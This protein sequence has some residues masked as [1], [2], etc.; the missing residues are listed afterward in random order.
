MSSDRTTDSALF[1]LWHQAKKT[2]IINRS[3]FNQTFPFKFPHIHISKTAVFREESNSDFMP[4]FS[5]KRFLRNRLSKCT[6][7]SLA[8]L[9]RE[10]TIDFYHT[11]FIL[12]LT[13]LRPQPGA[14]P[15]RQSMFVTASSQD[16]M[17]EYL[18]QGRAL[19]RIAEQI[20]RISFNTLWPP[21]LVR[22]SQ[23]TAWKDSTKNISK[24]CLL[25]AV[26]IWTTSKVFTTTR[27]PQS[28]Y[29]RNRWL[30][31]ES[32]IQARS[33]ILWACLHS[34]AAKVAKHSVCS[35]MSLNLKHSSLPWPNCHPVFLFLALEEGLYMIRNVLCT[36]DS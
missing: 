11:A 6:C 31:L 32:A 7:L 35:R 25:A 22:K 29:N 36:S 19:A 15:A 5:F 24:P 4:T 13:T 21:P 33:D 2:M 9:S 34:T 28:P 17:I 1:C 23:L 16:F 20:I 30:L 10:C 18:S 3:K 14:R 26:L 27:A 8:H 12:C